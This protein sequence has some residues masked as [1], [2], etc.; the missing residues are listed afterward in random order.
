[1]TSKSETR[2]LLKWCVCKGL[3]CGTILHLAARD[4]Q[5]SKMSSDPP[6]PHGE[7]VKYI[8]LEASVPSAYQA[9]NSDRD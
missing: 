7:A 4:P 1:M 3:S 9:V 5:I 8:N 6:A 2:H